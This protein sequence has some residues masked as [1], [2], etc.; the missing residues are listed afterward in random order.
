MSCFAV[1][2]YC[3]VWQSSSSSSVAARESSG[4]SRSSGPAERRPSSTASKRSGR[5]GCWRP[6]RW[7]RQTGSAAR[8]VGCISDSS[9]VAPEIHVQARAEAEALPL[10]DFGEPRS[11]LA[12]HFAVHAFGHENGVVAARA[13]RRQQAAHFLHVAGL[14]DHELELIGVAGHQFQ[15]WL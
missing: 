2:K 8:A 6:A 11:A 14:L 4:S 1:R 15:E 10:T 3:G 9:L 12:Q 7:P 5:S 13:N